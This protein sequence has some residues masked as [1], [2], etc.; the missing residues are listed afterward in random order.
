[1]ADTCSNTSPHKYCNYLHKVKK[2]TKPYFNAN[3]ANCNFKYNTWTRIKVNPNLVSESDFT[4]YETK[5]A[6]E[7]MIILGGGG[8]HIQSI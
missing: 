1:M 7:Y 8:R 3:F 2:Q 5:T 4:V 6:V